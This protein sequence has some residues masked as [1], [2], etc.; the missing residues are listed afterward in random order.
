MPT[1]HDHIEAVLDKAHEL[2]GG[3]YDERKVDPA[4][5]RF[6]YDHLSTRSA[7]HYAVKAFHL[8]YGQPVRRSPT[9]NIPESQFRYDLMA[10]ELEEY[11][12]GVL[13]RDV[14]DVA[15]ALADLMYTVYGTALAHG[16]PLDAVFDAVHRSNMTKDP[17]ADGGKPIKGVEYRA[18]YLNTALAQGE[19]T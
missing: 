3:S 1:F 8:K 14:V 19:D 7:A 18:P 2:Y 6:L 9:A 13:N 17:A 4:M 15:D 12:A 16:V 11:W 10:E 5:R